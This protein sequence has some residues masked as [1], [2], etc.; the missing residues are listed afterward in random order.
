MSTFDNIE[1]SG[2]TGGW[3]YD[4]PNMDY[5]QDID[6]DSGDF[7]TYNGL[8]NDSSFTNITKS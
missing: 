2:T 6:P 1:K 7:V 5:D 4:E 3:T 8:G